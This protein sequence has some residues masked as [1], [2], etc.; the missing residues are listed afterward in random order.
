MIVL[1]LISYFYSANPIRFK[2]IPSIDS[3]S[4]AVAI[5]CIAL[6]GLS[7]GNFSMNLLMKVFFVALCGSAAH[8][9]TTIPDYRC[10]KKA[11]QKTFSTFFGKRAP[12]L[13]AFVVF[14]SALFFAHIQ[15]MF[16]NYYLAMCA[17][18]ALIIGIY[19]NEKIALIITRILFFSFIVLAVI[20]MIFIF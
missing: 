3:L 15:T 12:A 8:A 11:K 10:D 7:F 19:P 1:L 5:F 9:L 2:E 6:L 18:S 4:N 14:L 16:I 13:F 20:F 17:L